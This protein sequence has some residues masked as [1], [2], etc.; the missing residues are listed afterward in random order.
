MENLFGECF[1]TENLHLA[2]KFC[3]MCRNKKCVLSTANLDRTQEE[4]STK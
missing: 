1:T 3:S 2:E 4:K